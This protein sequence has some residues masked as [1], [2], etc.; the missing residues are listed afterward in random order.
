V[1]YAVPSQALTALRA[2]EKEHE[3]AKRCGQAMAGQVGAGETV[4]T[5][6][7]TAPKAP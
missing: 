3:A 5:Y 4:V 2:L 7:C 6:V 1:E